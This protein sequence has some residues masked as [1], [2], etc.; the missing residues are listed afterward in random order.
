MLLGVLSGKTEEDVNEVN[1][2]SIASERGIV[3]SETTRTSA[4]DFTELVRVTLVSGEKRERVVGTTLGRR[5]RPHLLEAWGR[6]FNLQLED[7]LAL[8]RYRDLPGMIGRVGTIV[9][10]ARRE[11]RRR[12]RRL[13]AGRRR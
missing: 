13:R 5:H 8:F 2:P 7:G 9:R 6:R 10:R 4:R 1:A 12:R 11:H 3:T